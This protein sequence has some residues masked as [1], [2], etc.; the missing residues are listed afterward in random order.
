[1]NFGF[2]ILHYMAYEMTVK[3]VSSVLKFFSSSNLHIVVVDNASPDDSGKNLQKHFSNE[4][5]VDVILNR[6]N[7]GFA[8]GN[9]TGYDFLIDHYD[10]DFVIV[11]NNDVI[12]EQP[13]FLQKIAEKYEKT[14]FS[15]LGPDI[16]STSRKVHQNPF[17]VSVISEEELTQKS[18]YYHQIMAHPGFMYLEES[19]RYFFIGIKPIYSFVHTLSNFARIIFRKYSEEN[20][21]QKKAT[22]DHQKQL[23]M[24]WRQSQEDVVLFGACYIFSR[25]FIRK[26]PYCFYPDT[27]MY[28]EEQI[29][30]YECQ[31]D[32]LKTLYDPGLQVLHFEDVSTRQSLKTGYQR[33]LFKSR[34]MEKSCN[35]LLS[36]MRKDKEVTLPHS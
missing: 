29:L 7:L 16:Y 10:I 32:H 17:N 19:I 5:R 23:K 31:R 11:M 25:D 20:E 9:N 3:C 26:R 15:V 1:M 33:F 24:L 21:R 13:N 8:R 36:I 28:F 30:G 27:F 2:V 18:E 35:L 4:S 34:E 6:E 12:I 14:P 22:H